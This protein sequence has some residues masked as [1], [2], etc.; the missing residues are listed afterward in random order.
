MLSIFRPVSFLKG[1]SMYS[2]KPPK[3]AK[4]FLRTV[5]NHCLRHIS[6]KEPHSQSISIA[7]LKPVV[8]A[9]AHV[10]V[11]V[12]ERGG[13]ALADAAP[14]C[15][16]LCAVEAQ[17]GGQDHLDLL[18]GVA[19]KQLVVDVEGHGERVVGRGAEDARHAVVALVVDLGQG[20][21]LLEDLRVG[22]GGLGGVEG[23][24]IW[25]R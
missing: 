11:H 14:T 16:L 7:I 6:T 25:K 10:V 24:E 12:G 23:G 9:V 13:A 22:H 18:A 5:S 15:L 21:G 1:P 17:G 19:G 8:L 4:Y 3:L 20:E 2:S